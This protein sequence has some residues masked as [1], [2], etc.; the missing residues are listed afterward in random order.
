[1]P[2]KPINGFLYLK[3]KF[4]YFVDLVTEDKTKYNIEYFNNAFDGKD[5]GENCI[6]LSNKTENSITTVYKCKIKDENKIAKPA[7]SFDKDA[8]INICY[9]LCIKLFP[10]EEK[11]E[12]VIQDHFQTHNQFQEL[13]PKLSNE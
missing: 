5:V 11:E 2:K 9:K 6:I 12:E 7:H 8:L 4:A 13:Q 3:G 1:M 10:K